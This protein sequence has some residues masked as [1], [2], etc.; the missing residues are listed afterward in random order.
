MKKPLYPHPSKDGLTVDY[1]KEDFHKSLPYL[2]KELGDKNSLGH[3]QIDGIEQNHEDIA[4]NAHKNDLKDSYMDENLKIISE[5]EN[6]E[7]INEDDLVVETDPIMQ[8]QQKRREI[9]AYLEKQTK[10]SDNQELYN[11]KVEDF[12]RRCE[13]LQQ[14]DE[15]IAY[16]V[17]RGEISFEKAQFLR[18]KVKK[19][20]LTSY[21]PKKSW[22]Y[23]ERKYRRRLDFNEDIIN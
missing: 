17:K 4:E 7:F 2:A 13:N 22:G 14:A 5:E 21:G 11:P 12:I 20:G 3:L 9:E 1:D 6:P 16:L 8:L 15:I 23:F 18:D 10:S 19:E